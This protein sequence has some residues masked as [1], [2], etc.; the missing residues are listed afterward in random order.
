[1]GGHVRSLRNS[2][3]TGGQP[4]EVGPRVSGLPASVPGLVSRPCGVGRLGNGGFTRVCWRPRVRR[5]YVEGRG[6][7]EP[8]G[9]GARVIDEA[10][11]TPG[12]RPLL[13]PGIL[14]SGGEP[15]RPKGP[16]YRGKTAHGPGRPVCPVSRGRRCSRFRERRPRAPRRNSTPRRACYGPESGRLRAIRAHP[17]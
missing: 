7:G 12:P 16:E 5:F 8:I 13:G 4:L 3:N 6:L 10:R 9:A 2:S 1:M 14:E 17:T 15:R 11:R